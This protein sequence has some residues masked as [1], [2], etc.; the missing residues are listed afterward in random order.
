M[1]QIIFTG[2]LDRPGN[3]LIV[4]VS[5]ETKKNQFE[6]FTRNSDTVAKSA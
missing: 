5:E 1:Q 4:F 3:S 6:I 2:N